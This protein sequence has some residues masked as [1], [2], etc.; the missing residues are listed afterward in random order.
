MSCG[1]A[2][3][4]GWQHAVHT[5][6]YGTQPAWQETLLVHSKACDSHC[7]RLLLVVTVFC[8]PGARRSCVGPR[9]SSNTPCHQALI[10]AAGGGRGEKN[11]PAQTHR[12]HHGVAHTAAQIYLMDGLRQGSA[13]GMQV[14]LCLSSVNLG[15]PK[16]SNAA[17]QAN[18]ALVLCLAGMPAD[19]GPLC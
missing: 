14:Y 19:W 3:A 8:S 4:P 15:R 11:N 16:R 7:N 10:A 5:K 12:C 1:P 2:R 18:S 17:A 13:C 6:Q 9:C